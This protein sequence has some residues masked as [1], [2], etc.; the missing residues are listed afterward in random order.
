MQFGIFSIADIT[1]VV[2]VD[3]ARIV[4]IRPDDSHPHLQRWHAEIAQRDHLVGV[5]R[6]LAILVHRGFGRQRLT[7]ALELLDAA[8]GDGAGRP[9]D[10]DGE[11]TCILRGEAP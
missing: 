11:A 8:H 1:A 3:F 6:R 10:H 2:A 5:L 9:V 7:F 4:R